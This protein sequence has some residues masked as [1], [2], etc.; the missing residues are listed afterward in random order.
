MVAFLPNLCCD[1]QH[2]DAVHVSDWLQSWKKKKCLAV[3]EDSSH[4]TPEASLHSW[5]MNTLVIHLSCVTPSPIT[6]NPSDQLLS[7]TSSYTS[8]R[9]S[10]STHPYL[11]FSAVSLSRPQ[12][13]LT[14]VGACELG[15]DTEGAGLGGASAGLPVLS[16]LDQPLLAAVVGDKT[17]YALHPEAVPVHTHPAAAHS[18]RG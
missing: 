11:S 15:Q 13:W 18:R 14:E 10:E 16:V 1:D 4:L 3:T 7:Q 8:S 12:S 2:I 6:K 5:K 9:P 17:G